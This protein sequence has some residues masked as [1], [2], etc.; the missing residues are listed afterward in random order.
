MKQLVQMLTQTSQLANQRRCHF[1]TY[2][3]FMYKSV[4]KVAYLTLR[5]YGL[6]SKREFWLW[7]LTLANSLLSN[8]EAVLPQ[9]K[10]NLLYR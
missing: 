10:A 2:S 8:R 6:V 7:P 4:F 5:L 9:R 3:R 1:K